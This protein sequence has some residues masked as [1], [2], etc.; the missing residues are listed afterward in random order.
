MAEF[1][2]VDQPEWDPEDD[3]PDYQ[4]RDI[5]YGEGEEIT[6]TPIKVESNLYDLLIGQLAVLELDERRRKV[7]E[8]IVGSI[9]EDG[10]L[11][12]EIASIVDD[13]AFRQ[14]VQTSDEEVE[15][16]DRLKIV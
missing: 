3:I 2:S 11:R 7:A 5:N 6:P 4:T 9:D 14:N 8:Q 15:L 13:L 10:Y 12:R 1:G 16:L